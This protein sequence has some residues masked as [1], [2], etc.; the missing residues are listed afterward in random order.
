MKP[1]FENN[2][3]NQKIINSIWKT[4]NPI[5]QE[6][7]NK[8]GTDTLKEVEI[9]NWPAFI[10]EFGRIFDLRQCTNKR[11]LV[12]NIAPLAQ[13]LSYL[14]N[15]DI[16]Y[17]ST[18]IDK[19][20]ETRER[21][22]A[23]IS[24]FV[25]PDKNKMINVNKYL[26]M[27][28]SLNS[29]DYVIGNPNYDKDLYLCVAEGCH[30]F[31][32][33]GGKEMILGPT[34]CIDNPYYY[35]FVNK[36]KD[37]FT[38]L[39]GVEYLSNEMIECFESFNGYTNLAVFTFEKEKVFVDI[40]KLWKNGKNGEEISLVEKLMSKKIVKISDICKEITNNGIFV[41][42]GDIGGGKHYLVF[43]K[44]LC[45]KNGMVLCNVSGKRKEYSLKWLTT[46]ECEKKNIKYSN[47]GI[48]VNSLEEAET[49]Y[50][51]YR[52]FDTLRGICTMSRFGSQHVKFEFIPYYCT[53]NEEDIIKDLR[54]DTNEI[55]ILKN[56]SKSDSYLKIRFCV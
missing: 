11:I 35:E 51:S 8:F 31:L 34:L 52:N 7:L 50:N 30:P 21:Y 22:P 37:L 20:N 4:R 23:I 44:A 45:V 13:Y 39:S 27:K 48:K 1:L 19:I 15:A 29:F 3:R 9:L 36:H 10:K 14:D 6:K 42:I 26:D 46:K 56:Y 47:I 49:V 17:M 33:E 41:P 12:I 55:A 28:T 25:K 32:K 43:E 38:H 5:K 16:I 54:L 53:N 2:E 40:N 18:D 24:I